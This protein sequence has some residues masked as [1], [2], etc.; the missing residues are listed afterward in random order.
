[1]IKLEGRTMKP[2]RSVQLETM[3]PLNDTA[4]ANL[5]RLLDDPTNL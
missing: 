3:Q 2:V 5:P 4:A 1:M